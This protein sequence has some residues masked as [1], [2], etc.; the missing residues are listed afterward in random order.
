MANTFK[1]QFLLKLFAYLVLLFRLQAEKVTLYFILVHTQAT[2]LP[3]SNSHTHTQSLPFALKL[4][5]TY[6]KI[7]PVILNKTLLSP[8]LT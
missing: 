2:K 8:L 6:S 1:F 5:C 4:D 3:L 7:M